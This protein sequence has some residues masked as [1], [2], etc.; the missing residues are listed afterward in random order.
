MLNGLST[1]DSKYSAELLGNIGKAN[2]NRQD[3]NKV[4]H[5]AYYNYVISPK[6]VAEPAVVEDLL[7]GGS[8]FKVGSK[9]ISATNKVLSKTGEP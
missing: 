7:I 2:R 1:S 6:G 3:N 8:V 9:A 4:L 5:N